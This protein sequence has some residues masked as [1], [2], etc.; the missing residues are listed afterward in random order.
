LSDA[1]GLSGE[2][3]QSVAITGVVQMPWDEWEQL[4]GEAL[5]RQRTSAQMRLNQ[6][7]ADSGS[8][9]GAQGD[10]LVNQ[11]DLAK[12]GNAAFELHQ[13][14]RHDSA[15]ARTSSLKAVGGLKREGLA[16]GAALEHVTERWADQVRSLLDATAHISN[17][18]DYTKNAHAGDEVHIANTLSSIATL[19]KGFDERKGS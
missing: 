6:L 9:S 11:G 1:T 16:I 5:E 12:V 3:K 8:S 19:D 4:K 17:H 13:A 14:F 15:H 2:G 10:L 7:P 18:L